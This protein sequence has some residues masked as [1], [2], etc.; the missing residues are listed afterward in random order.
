MV[1]RHRNIWEKV[2]VQAVLCL[3]YYANLFIQRLLAY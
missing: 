2:T 1:Y 3:D